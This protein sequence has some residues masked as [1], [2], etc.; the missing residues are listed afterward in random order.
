MKG[1]LL[2]G[3]LTADWELDDLRGMERQTV[4]PDDAVRI[5]EHPR[6]RAARHVPTKPTEMPW[7]ERLLPRADVTVEV[8]AANGRSS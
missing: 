1:E 5:A 7:V 2:S 8:P 3:R 4:A 6:E